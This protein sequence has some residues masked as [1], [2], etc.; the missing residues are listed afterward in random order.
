MNLHRQ[1]PS[2]RHDH[3]YRSFVSRQRSLILDLAEEREEEC[4]G[5]ARTGFGDA[6]DIATG[7][8]GGNCLRLNG[9][10]RFVSQ[11]LDDV[12]SVCPSIWQP[13]GSKEGDAHDAGQATVRPLCDWLRAVRTADLDA[14]EL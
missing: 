5:L 13:S 11:V 10:G 12:E 7:H 14:V 9:R 8:D 2:R 1:F 4:D 6:D 3:R